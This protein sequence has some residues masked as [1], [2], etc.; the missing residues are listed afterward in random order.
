MALRTKV[1]V[2]ALVV[3]V[4]AV[5]GGLYWFLSGD[6]PPEASLEGALAGRTTTT[7]GPAGA[8]T[9]AAASAGSVE[10]TWTVDTSTGGFDF[11]SATGT[12]AGFRIQENLAGIGATHAVGRT[13]AV[14]GSMTVT[15]TAVT[16]A[17]FEVDL[18]S[19]RSNDSRRN[20]R[21]QEALET[22]RF[23]TATFRLTSPIQLGADA[24]T[25]KEVEVVAAGDLTIHGTT[26]PVQFPLQAQLSG[27]TI[28]VAG[29]LDVDFADYGVR[30]PRSQIVVSVEDHGPIELQL[31]LTRSG[32]A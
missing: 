13:G 17:D 4:L 25:G 6:E 2:G 20:A 14:S 28:A 29:S 15:G 12:F 27:D 22:D 5:S 19:I 32:A 11:E 1:L 18:T 3:A 31:L 16:A 21:I 8:A 24:T 30:V 23:P 10:G 7:A 26:E 9:D